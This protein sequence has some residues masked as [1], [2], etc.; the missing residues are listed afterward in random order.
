MIRS[1]DAGAIVLVV[2]DVIDDVIVRPLEPVTRGS[3][4]RAR[5]EPSLGGSGANQAAWLAHHGATVRFAGRVGRA[6]LPR[7]R[8]AFTSAGVEAHL[9]ADDEVATGTIVVIVDPDDAERTMYTDRGAN[10]GLR[11][12]DLPDSLLEDVALLHVSGYSLFDANVRE[13]VLDLTGRARR[14]GLQVSVD[15]A[16]VAF[17]E[18]VGPATFLRWV[19]GVDLLLPNLD[20]GRLLTGERGPAAIAT[21]LLDHAE[22]VALKLGAEGALVVRRGS[23]ALSVPAVAG[24]IVDTTGAGDA[25]C[26]AFLAGWIQGRALEEL[27]EAAV[28]AGARAAAVPGARPPVA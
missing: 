23:P 12:E 3:D 28:V 8:Q 22:V 20:E 24:E 4:T 19:D 25:F 17:L 11:V 26:G 21:R 10:L 2:G 18:A 9:A 6:D 7:H 13:A 27:A 14:R 15:P 16:S 1:G 5:I